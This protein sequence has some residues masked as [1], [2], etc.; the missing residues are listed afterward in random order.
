MKECEG[1][2][3]PE[4][5]E[6]SIMGSGTFRK[7]HNKL[8][9]GTNSATYHSSH[10][11][12]FFHPVDSKANRYDTWMENESGT[13]LL[14]KV[15]SFTKKKPMKKLHHIDRTECNSFCSNS[16]WQRIKIGSKDNENCEKSISKY[17]NSL[18]L[19]ES[20][21]NT[22]YLK[23]C[24]SL[25][26]DN[27]TNINKTNHRSILN[28]R[29]KCHSKHR[30]CKTFHNDIINEP[31]VT[32]SSTSSSSW[33]SRKTNETTRHMQPILSKPTSY[34]SL[35]NNKVTYKSKENPKNDSNVKY[36]NNDQEGGALAGR[37]KAKC[38]HYFRTR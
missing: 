25:K 8:R 36:Y 24:A 17:Q 3:S 31:I 18:E 9:W 38:N 14:P 16:I 7:E 28:R 35:S 4:N 30:M 34:S 33:N 5:L 32:D 29:Y 1:P 12:N 15:K 13:K 27:Y 22:T 11:L 19:S 2:N 23:R 26:L 6:L 37:K 21:A 20:H 10:A